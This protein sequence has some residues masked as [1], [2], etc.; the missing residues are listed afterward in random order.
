VSPSSGEAV[1]D[2]A[3]GAGGFLVWAAQHSRGLKLFGIEKDR[4]LAALARARTMMMGEPAIVHCANSLSFDCE[5]SDIKPNDLIGTF[6]VVLTNPPFGKNIQSVSAAVQKS[7]ELGRK[8]KRHRDGCYLQTSELASK[9]PPQVLFLERIL[10]LLKKGGRAGIVVP[11]SMI[12]S[13][14]YGHVVQYIRTH[15]SVKA[16]IGMPEALF[17]SSGKGGRIRKLVSSS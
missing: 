6:D 5:D 8:W 13:R 9:A 14:S 4:Y 3:C 12:S 10:S 1:I 15:S 17:K 16:I 11:E 7:F 2:P